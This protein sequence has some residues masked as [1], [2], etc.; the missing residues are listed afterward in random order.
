MH[1]SIELSDIYSMK[2]KFIVKKKDGNLVLECLQEEITCKY[3]PFL[4]SEEELFIWENI[5]ENI[6]VQEIEHLIADIFVLDK[7]STII[8]VEGF[9]QQLKKHISQ[10]QQHALLTHYK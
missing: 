9:L 2:S 3:I 10:I 4:M 7:Y 6:T 1:T 8:C 5:H